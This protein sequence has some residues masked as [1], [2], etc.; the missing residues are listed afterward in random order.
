MVTWAG[1]GGGGRG[2]TKTLKHKGT[3]RQRQIDKN[4]RDLRK[5]EIKVR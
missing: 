1:G 4:I 2:K 5:P 3:T